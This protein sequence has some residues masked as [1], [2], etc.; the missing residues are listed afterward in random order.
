MSLPIQN[1]SRRRG[2]ESGG[3]TNGGPKRQHRE[4]CNQVNRFEWHI[5]LVAWREREVQSICD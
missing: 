4:W 5:E 1:A 2:D 3:R